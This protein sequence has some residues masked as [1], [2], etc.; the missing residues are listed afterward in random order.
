[1]TEKRINYIEQSFRLNNIFSLVLIISLVASLLAISLNNL[2]FVTTTDDV[3]LLEALI[4]FV[5]INFLPVAMLLKPLISLI[6]KVI[7]TYT[8]MKARYYISRSLVSILG[9]IEKILV[10]KFL[11]SLIPS[12]KEHVGNGIYLLDSGT[13]LIRNNDSLL[14]TIIFSG[15][16]VIVPILLVKEIKTLIYLI[17]LKVLSNE[18]GN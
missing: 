3:S 6:L 1:M 4:G 2:I 8:V 11:I 7:V 12:M 18:R 10:T 13:G 15:L 14:L 17:G 9:I 5:V 16:M